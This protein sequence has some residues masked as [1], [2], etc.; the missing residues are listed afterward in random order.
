MGQYSF[1][2]DGQ[3]DETED[4]AE[5]D[6]DPIDWPGQFRLALTVSA[7]AA[8]AAVTLTPV[9]GEMALIVSVIVGATCVSWFRLER[10]DAAHRRRSPNPPHDRLV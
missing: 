10:Q 7:V 2:D 5:D 3:G 1:D 6:D 9:I 4:D 8:V